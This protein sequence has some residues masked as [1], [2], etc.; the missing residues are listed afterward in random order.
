M[1]IVSVSFA[2]RRYETTGPS[3]WFS[4]PVVLIECL[5]TVRSSETTVRRQI[6]ELLPQKYRIL[7][8][9]TEDVRCIIYTLRQLP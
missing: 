9:K 7:I 1:V 6:V 4:V 2:M 5:F 8:K 3:P